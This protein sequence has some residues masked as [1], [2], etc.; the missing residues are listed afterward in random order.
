[1]SKDGVNI[2]LHPRQSRCLQSYA[3]EILYG[4]A[5]GGGKS[6]L[7]RAAA[8]IWCAEIPGLQVYLFRRLLPD[9]TKNHMEG[10][11]GFRAMLAPWVKMKFVQI[12]EEEIRF[13]NGSKIYLCHCKDEKDR[14]KY[15]GPEI[16]V[17]L[18]DE[19]THFTE[20]IYRFLRTRV[21][22]TGIKLPPKHKN[23]FPRIICSSNPGNVGHHWVKSSFIDPAKPMQLWQTPK[24]EGGMIRQFIPAKLDDNPTLALE[25]P[26]YRLRLKGLGSPE[27][28]KA[29]EDGDW[30]VIAGAFFS[31]WRNN[32]IVI[33][34][35]NVP[36]KWLKFGAF[37]FGSARPFSYGLWAMSD[38][39]DT[40]FKRGAL[41]KIKEWYGACGPNQGLKM[42]V[43]D[44]A[45][46]I[47]ERERGYKVTYRVADPSIFKQEGG[48]S[49]AEEFYRNGV[50]FRKAD[51]SRINGWNQ[52]RSRII[53]EED[54][55]MIYFC[56]NCL[57]SIRTIPA[58]VHDDHQIEDVDTDCEDHAADECRYACMSR[59]WY[60]PVRKSELSKATRSDLRFDDLVL[61]RGYITEDRI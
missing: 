19:L 30:N 41:I 50:S 31:E 59:P 57:D 26:E 43:P 10:P 47:L 22:M 5:A 56:E 25:D 14:F 39:E 21:R 46:G 42:K 3:T 60:P 9:L 34:A 55:P 24:E 18:I 28:V 12:L 29:M 51:N 13:K 54:E 2:K 49:I 32:K 20:I 40:R 45:K 58:M 35:F 44:I 36:S 17:L 11:S 7:M 23:H 52:V 6:F 27:L 33:P 8:M 48:P 38:G 61:S 15:Q 37:D 16:H 53:G 1:M 4:G